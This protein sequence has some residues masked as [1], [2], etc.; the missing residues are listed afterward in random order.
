MS[1]SEV[2]LWKV[3]KGDQQGVRFRRQVPVGPYVLDFYA[4]S[5]RLAIEV[6]GPMHEEQKDAIRDLYLQDRGLM[7]LRISSLGVRRELD[8]I[9]LLEKIYQRLSD[10]QEGSGS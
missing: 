6:D 3:L 10:F 8:R 9:N 5:I 2:I 4:P 1:E 7:V